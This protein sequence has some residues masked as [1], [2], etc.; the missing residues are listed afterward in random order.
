MRIM[1]IEKIKKTIIVSVE[2]ERLKITRK[3]IELYLSDVKAAIQKNR[4]RIDRNSKRQDNLDL[5]LNYMIDE[6]KAKRILLSLTPADFSEIRQ[7]EHKGFEHEQLYVF[8]KDVA[9]SRRLD[10]GDEKIPLYIKINKL[11]NQFVIIVSFHKQ[12]YPLTYAFPSRAESQSQCPHFC[13]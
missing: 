8:G 10:I 5:F 6:A 9:L 13:A 1:M 4:Y 3:D 7:N 2:E 12:T 11:D